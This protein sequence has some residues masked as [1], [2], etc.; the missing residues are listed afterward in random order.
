MQIESFHLIYDACYY[1]F[2][3][4]IIKYSR[5]SFC[6]YRE[7]LEREYLLSGSKSRSTRF[8]LIRLVQPLQ[9]RGDRLSSMMGAI[10]FLRL[11]QVFIF[12]CI[13]LLENV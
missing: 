1:H 13:L 11:N 4:L 7:E 6:D 2:G 10:L 12:I 3:L 8:D 5:G 9:S